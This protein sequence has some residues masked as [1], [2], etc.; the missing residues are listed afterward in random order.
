MIKIGSVTLG[1]KGFIFKY[2]ILRNIQ[3]VHE[4]YLNLCSISWDSID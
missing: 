4:A 3:A 1:I 2:D